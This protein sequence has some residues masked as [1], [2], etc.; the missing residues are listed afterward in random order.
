MEKTNKRNIRPFDGE[1][2]SIWK[3]R[4]RAL[5]NEIDVLKVIDQEE[6]ED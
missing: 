2:Y 3:F 6:E 5:L 4:I 1:K